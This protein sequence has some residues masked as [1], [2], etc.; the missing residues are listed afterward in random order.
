LSKGALRELSEHLA[1]TARSP[2]HAEADD[3]EGADAESPNAGVR[4]APSHDP[5]GISRSLLAIGD[6]VQRWLGAA[7]HD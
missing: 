6:T 1:R 7:E 2:E 4:D 5:I 3:G